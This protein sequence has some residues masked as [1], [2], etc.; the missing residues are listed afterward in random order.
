MSY[1]PKGGTND[2]CTLCTHAGSIPN[3]RGYPAVASFFDFPTIGGTRY[4]I[5]TGSIRW[6][7]D[8]YAGAVIVLNKATVLAKI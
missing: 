2:G 3:S 6:Q 1:V 7:S 5:A 4:L 8:S